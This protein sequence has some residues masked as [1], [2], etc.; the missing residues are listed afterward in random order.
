MLLDVLISIDVLRCVVCCCGEEEEE[1]DSR[2]E[3]MY[4]LSIRTCSEYSPNF[5]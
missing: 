5:Q 2:K 4:G 1:E 3:G